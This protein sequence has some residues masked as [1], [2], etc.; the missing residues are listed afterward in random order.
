VMEDAYL[1]HSATVAFAKSAIHNG[2][3]NWLTRSGACQWRGDVP[4]GLDQHNFGV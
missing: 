4:P 2:F 1:W 3:R